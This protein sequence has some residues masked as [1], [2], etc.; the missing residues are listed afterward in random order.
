MRILLFGTGTIYQRY[1]KEFAPY[2]IVAL[3]DNDKEK[4]G[5][6]LDGHTIL[7]PE[8]GIKLAYDYVFILVFL[9]KAET[10]IEQLFQLHVPR[11][12]I[13]LF[14]WLPLV[15]DVSSQNLPWHICPETVKRVA[16]KNERRVLVLTDN[17]FITGAETVLL[18]ALRVL[19]K[20]GFSIFVLARMDGPMRQKFEKEG[21]F[22]SVEEALFQSSL[23]T[24]SWLK[25]TDFDL[26]F[27][28][29]AFLYY[30]F[31]NYSGK[32]PVF[33]WLHD[34]DSLYR[35]CNL[36]CELLTEVNPRN[37]YV[38]AVGTVAQQAFQKRLPLWPVGILP[39]G[40]ASVDRRKERYVPVNGRIVFFTAGDLGERKGQA[41]LI[42]AVRL[43][44]ESVRTQCR[45]C[46][47]YQNEKDG[48]TVTKFKE[49]AKGIPE[50]EFLG[51][52]DAEDMPA[53]YATSDVLACP[54]LDDTLPAVCIE[55]MR[56]GVPCLM[57]KEVG[58]SNYITDGKEG[59]IVPAD[60][61]EALAE[62]IRWYV[63]HREDIPRMGEN[64]RK[65]YEKYFTEKV[66]EEHF[67]KVIK[68]IL[69]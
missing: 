51:C 23:G 29:T 33:W 10:I 22:C 52:V 60:D 67:L 54:S 63:Q 38:Y 49:M 64:A 6:I 59:R 45:F 28:N 32:T 21:F 24:M 68:G 17:F 14:N 25:E 42:Q 43:L 7:P 56:A 69:A 46:L 37:V 61:A 1:K 66:F 27:V 9:S 55:A 36:L 47:A 12:K 65:V 58:V 20:Y 15:A 34:S 26:V 31:K 57:T 13:C 44:P 16:E 40:I 8:E 4:Q 62:A 41:V 53:F 18:Q 11:E 19:R 48:Q 30:L 5:T 50:I 3:L 39:Y 35:I 2:E